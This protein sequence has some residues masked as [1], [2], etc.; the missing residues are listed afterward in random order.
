MRYSCVVER[1]DLRIWLAST[2]RETESYLRERLLPFWMERILEPK[3][4]GFRTAYDQDGRPSGE[5]RKTLLCQGRSIFAL[6]FAAR[7]GWYARELELLAREGSRFLERFRDPEHGGYFWILEEDGTVKDDSKVVYG[8]SFMIY[9]MSELALLTGDE[10]AC[11][12]ACSLFDLVLARAADIG[13]GGF[14]EH[15]DRAFDLAVVRPDGVAHKSLDVH[16]HLM[17]AFTTLYELTGR[18]RHRRALVEIVELIHGRMVD[19]DTGCGISMFAPDW[20]PIANVQLATVWGSDRFQAGKP[21][22]MTSY[23]HNVELAWLT[24]RAL[25]VLARRPGGL[26]RRPGG[27][28]AG[29]AP[30]PA[31]G[32]DEAF[33]RSR[34]E[35]LFRH[36]VERGVDREYGGLYV[37]G[38]RDGDATDLD[39]EFWQQ[40]EAMVGFLDAWLLL[41][42]ERY[43]EAFRLV[44]DFV[45]RHLV[46]P[47]LGE[48]HALADRRGKVLRGYLGHGWKIC[49]H[50]VRATCLVVEKLRRILQE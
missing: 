39:K 47:R 34:V 40:G 3:H 29:G 11:D 28:A 43:L 22:E 26:A 45:F 13:R 48:W 10:R 33:I 49:Y 9:A 30:Q 4:G 31:A 44:H 21:P 38:L 20:T 37:E 7:H 42:D 25:D 35:R 16:M 17:E 19:P 12:E 24:L 2:L 46:H 14:F 1:N 27:L 18:E 23:G 36:T 50:T 15:F 32:L 5:T 6:S 41:G 8:L